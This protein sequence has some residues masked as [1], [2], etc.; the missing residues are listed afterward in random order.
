MSASLLLVLS[1]VLLTSVLGI[2]AVVELMLR[3]RRDEP[4]P[5]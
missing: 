5:R 3:D 4:G 2:V 1:A